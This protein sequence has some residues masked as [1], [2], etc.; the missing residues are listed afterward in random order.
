MKEI[1]KEIVHRLHWFTQIIYID[2]L[3]CQWI[4]YIINCKVI[5]GAFDTFRPVGK[6]RHIG[7]KGVIKHIDYPE[8]PI[9]TF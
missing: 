9:F 3:Q 1:K 8:A 5:Q 7:R 4:K 6:L 2:Y